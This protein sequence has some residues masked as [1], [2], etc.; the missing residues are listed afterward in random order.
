MSLFSTLSRRNVWYS[1]I[2]NIAKELLAAAKVKTESC[3]K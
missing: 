1:K 2:L 3:Y